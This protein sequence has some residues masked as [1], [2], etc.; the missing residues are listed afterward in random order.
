MFII[1]FIV[2]SLVIT[3]QLYV[4]GLEIFSTGGSFPEDI[5][6]LINFAYKYEDPDQT[7]I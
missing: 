3:E 6:R 7:V 5:Y 1:N 4:E 2:L